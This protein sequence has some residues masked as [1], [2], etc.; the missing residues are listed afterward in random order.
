VAEDKGVRVVV[1]H[2][3]L[4]L[5]QLAG[6]GEGDNHAGEARRA[7]SLGLGVVTGRAYL[8][9]SLG[10][11]PG[12]DP[13]RRRPA[14]GQARTS[15]PCCRDSSPLTSPTGTVRTMRGEYSSELMIAADAPARNAAA[16]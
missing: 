14:G 2:G 11:P 6:A 15:S 1:D 7:W 4:V 5:Q 13:A 12:N 3:V 10:L 8:T 16:A 9:G